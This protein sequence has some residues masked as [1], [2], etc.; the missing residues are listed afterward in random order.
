MLYN[1]G[2]TVMLNDLLAKVQELNKRYHASSEPIYLKYRN[3][4][5]SFI[6]KIHNGYDL[7]ESKSLVETLGRIDR[8][9]KSTGP[10]NRY[11]KNTQ[12]QLN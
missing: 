3:I 11:N 10:R 12:S 1:K 9:L 6:D 4:L 8:L 5:F 7:S 2:G